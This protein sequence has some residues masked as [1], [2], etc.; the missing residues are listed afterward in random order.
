MVKFDPVL[1]SRRRG[2]L[3]TCLV[4]WNFALI[5]MASI[6]QSGKC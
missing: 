1:G 4:S 3:G 5:L 6:V 2:A